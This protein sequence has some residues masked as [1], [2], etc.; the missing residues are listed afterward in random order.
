MINI[1]KMRLPFLGFALTTFLMACSVI[2]NP[3]ASSFQRVKYNSHLKLAKKQDINEL[4]A[5]VRAF[6]E[7]K[8]LTEQIFQ[9]SASNAG[10]LE[11]EHSSLTIL[12]EMKK[13]GQR[14]VSG[15]VK[16]RLLKTVN[17][18]QF[19][20]ES[21]KS[22]NSTVEWWEDDPEDWPW[23]EIVLAVIAVLLI[24]LI[25]VLIIDLIGGL[26]GTLL[27]IILLLLLAYFLIEY[28]Y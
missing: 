9:L 20:L 2:K 23:Q 11:R 15:F 21:S 27:G 13:K 3:Q 10:D 12:K 7:E 8:K 5:T 17:Q 24:V 16:E 4:P 26:L 22:S 25:V 6:P 19:R 28:W 18:E 14:E 1:K